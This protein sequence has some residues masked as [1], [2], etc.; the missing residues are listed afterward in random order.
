MYFSAFQYF[1]A[2]AAEHKKA[3]KFMGVWERN[4]LIESQNKY[5][6]K[7]FWKATFVK[8]WSKLLPMA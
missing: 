1:A 7:N 3:L 4:G 2:N 6:P 5:F 8:F